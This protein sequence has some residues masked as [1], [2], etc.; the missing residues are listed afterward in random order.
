MREFTE[1]LP[2]L[3]AFPL[4]PDA[5]G[6]PGGADDL[7]TFLSDVLDHVSQQAS[8]HERDRFWNATINERGP[9]EPAQHAPVP[10][11]DRPPA[12]TDVLLGYV[13]SLDQLRWID[14]TQSY[15]L[16]AGSRRGSVELPGRELNAPLLLLY[17]SAPGGLRVARLA[18]RGPWRA[19]DDDDL[20]ATGYPDPGG[21]LYFVTSLELVPAVPAWLRRVDLERLRPTDLP[22][23]APF[24][25]T[26]WELL[27][28]TSPG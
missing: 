21:R 12:D 7:K 16:C 2:G 20:K 24:V 18:R 15:N 9:S 3:G 14:D 13:R 17:I 19:V 25:R 22:R 5:Y 10:F 23:G 8:K 26:W 4:R 1:L 28:N 11:L 27:A 6:E